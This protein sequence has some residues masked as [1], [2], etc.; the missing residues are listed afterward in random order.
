[1]NNL[2]RIVT[3]IH[4][5]EVIKCSFSNPEKKRMARRILT[6]KRVTVHGPGEKLAAESHCGVRNISVEIL[7]LVLGCVSSCTMV[8]QLISV[9]PVSAPVHRPALGAESTDLWVNSNWSLL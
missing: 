9:T 1:M 7:S 6:K 5:Y 8:A 2:L 3:S 4:I